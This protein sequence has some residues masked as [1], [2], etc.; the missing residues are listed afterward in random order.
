[1]TSPSSP[2]VLGAL[3][4]LCSVDP[5][6]LLFTWVGDDGRDAGTLTAGG[7]GEATDKIATALRGWGLRAGDRAVLVYPPGLDFIA[8]FTGCLAAGVVPVPVYP[9]DPTR[10]GR[11]MDTFAKIVADCGARAALTNATYDRARKIA[12]VAGFFG[13][14]TTN[15]PELSWYRTDRRFR[16][17][18]GT[19]AR[20][21]PVSP[22]ETA[23]LQYT[24][25]ST[26]TPKGVVVTH[27]NI[28]HE[29]AAN[30][31]DLRLHDGTRGV[32]W[33]PQY[34]DMGLINVI[35]ST[36]CGNSATHL[37][38]PVTFLR[39]PAVWFAVMSRVGATITSAPNFAYDLA[40]RKTTAAQ[41]AGWDLKPAGDGDLRGRTGSR[42]DGP[43][44]H[45]GVR[46]NRAP[47]GRLLRRVRP[48]REHRQCHQSGTRT[49]GSRQRRA[50]PRTGR[51]DF[52][53]RASDDP[54]WLRPF[55]QGGR[56]DQDRRPGH[57]PAVRGRAGRGGLGA[58]HDHHGQATGVGRS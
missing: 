38:S 52:R 30:V 1:M 2:T 33:I 4:R 53:D 42:P 24:S 26:G 9:P 39:D 55:Q 43:R 19:V 21:E 36:V 51:E 58:V 3:R 20:H 41:R 11:S 29:L 50:G 44:V 25:G 57:P 54:P 6:R 47:R 14:S 17:D 35:L 23:F 31:T 37:M 10:P 16:G 13:R 45:G 12:A 56:R 32:F 27:G 48:G 15:V 7:L 28:A 34:H 18:A 46:R 8:A 22:D 5:A 40:V 49:G